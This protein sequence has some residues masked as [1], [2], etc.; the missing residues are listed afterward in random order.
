[1][2]KNSQDEIARAYATL[3][4]LRKNI[5]KILV[6]EKYVREYHAVLDKL[7]GVG[8]DISEFRIPYSEIEPMLSST[9]PSGNFY[10]EEN[11]R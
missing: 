8:I 4:S 2:T 7:E 6:S 9:S 3:L 11:Q 5:E 1:M 10:S